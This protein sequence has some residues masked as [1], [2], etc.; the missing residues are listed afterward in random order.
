MDLRSLYQLIRLLLN[1][2]LQGHHLTRNLGVRL[3]DVILVVPLTLIVV[4]AP[5]GDTGEMSD[6]VTGK[7]HAISVCSLNVGIADGNLYQMDAILMKK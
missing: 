1:N 5:G 2:H 4:L 6:R 7:V 3:K